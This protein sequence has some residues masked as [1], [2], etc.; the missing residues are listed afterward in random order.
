MC[1]NVKKLVEL[2]RGHRVVIQTHD[3]PDADAMASAFGLQWILAQYEIASE[4]I[5]HGRID[6]MNNRKMQNHFQIPMRNLDSISDLSEESYVI[7]IDGQKNNSN[8]RNVIG[9]EVAC[10]DHHPWVTDYKYEYVDHRICGACASIIAHY[11][12][13]MEVEPPKNVATVLL[14]GLKKDTK[15]FCFG[16][17]GYDIEAFA[18]LHERADNNAIMKLEQSSLELDDLHA[19]GDAFRNIRIYDEVGFAHIHFDCPDG[20]IASISEFILSLDAVT[21]AV[22]YADRNNGYKFSVRSEL[23]WLN[24]GKLINLALRDIGNG[25]GHHSM[26]GGLIY[27]ERKHLLGDRASQSIQQRFLAVVDEIKEEYKKERK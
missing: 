24:A 20:L 2:V 17:T 13:E 8:F 4:L 21:I 22:V 5:Y 16:V 27:A 12:M 18:Y 9:K 19:Y 3:F 15:N 10:I 6:K 23:S 14:Y 7:N 26:A 25:G 1:D 11:I